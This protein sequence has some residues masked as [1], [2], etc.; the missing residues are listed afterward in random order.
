MISL[1]ARYQQRSLFMLV[2]PATDRGMIA[3]LSCL[4]YDARDDVVRLGEATIRSLRA[5]AFD[6]TQLWAWCS[7]PRGSHNLEWGQ[8]HVTELQ[9]CSNRALHLHNASSHAHT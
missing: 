1:Y 5:D 6:A 2:I 8:H 7:R 4:A 9:G 3:V